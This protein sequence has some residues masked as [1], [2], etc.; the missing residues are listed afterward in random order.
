MLRSLFDSHARFAR[1]VDAFVDGELP[2]GPTARFAAHL[3]SC[4]SCGRT[5]AEARRAKAH[6]ASLPEQSLPRSFILTPEMAAA[7]A[8]ATPVPRPAL[9][10]ATRAVSA[11]AVAAFVLFGT[12]QLTGTGEDSPASSD[13]ASI[14][15]PE[16]AS[17]KSGIL[18]IAAATGSPEAPA[19]AEA[20]VASPPPPGASG[21]AV[22]PDATAT[23]TAGNAG[24]DPSG[25]E[26]GSG[27][28]DAPLAQDSGSAG[29][30]ETFAFAGDSAADDGGSPPWKPAIIASGAVALAA[31]AAT[32]TLEIRRRRS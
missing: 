24:G 6:V 13:A 17:A 11:A 5:V 15:L 18:E 26:A 16:D 28:A 23:D 30:L 7:P 8:R 32:G 19:T 12:L 20:G 14:G 25:G 10:Y 9:L 4:S 3:A 2:D 21:A 31:I 1:D 29:G 27:P 22:E